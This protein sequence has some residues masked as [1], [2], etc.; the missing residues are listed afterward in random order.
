MAINVIINAK[1]HITFIT[2]NQAT[3]NSVKGFVTCFLS[4]NMRMQGLL[5]LIYCIHISITRASLFAII[6]GRSAVAIDI[7][8]NNATVGDLERAIRETSGISLPIIIT[9]AGAILN[10]TSQSLADVGVG[11]E[12]TVHVTV[13]Y[14]VQMVFRK[15]VGSNIRGV[16]V[17]DPIPGNKRSL[18]VSIDRDIIPQIAAQFPDYNDANQWRM[19]EG[20][21]LI[22]KVVTL[23]IMD[24]FGEAEIILVPMSHQYPSLKRSF[25][26]HVKYNSFGDILFCGHYGVFRKTSDGVFRVTFSGRNVPLLVLNH[27][28]TSRAWLAEAPEGYEYLF[29]KKF[30]D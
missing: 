19:I 13:S 18:S 24:N 12:T 7:D 8:L 20:N 26:N 11:S 10:G 22:D 17:Y 30:G 29:K 3:S 2:S 28:G 14:E 1:Q 15:Y 25:H 27:M 4:H 16:W 23:D 5:T 6:D 21:N 9:H